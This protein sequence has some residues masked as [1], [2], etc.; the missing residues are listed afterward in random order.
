[1]HSKKNILKTVDYC[2][3]T[4]VYYFV[5]HHITINTICLYE[6]RGSHRPATGLNVCNMTFHLLPLKQPVFE[7]PDED[8]FE[9]GGRKTIK[10]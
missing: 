9:K 10:D 8:H 4:G 1:M 6:L 5:N 3:F 7:T 2:F